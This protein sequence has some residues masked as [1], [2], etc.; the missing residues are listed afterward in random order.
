M[1]TYMEHRGS[2]AGKKVAWIGDGNNMCQ[3]YML[4]AKQFG[5][6]LHIACPES[7]EPNAALQKKYAKYI[8][9]TRSPEDAARNADLLVTDVWASMG[10]EEEQKKRELAFANYQVNPALLALA[11]S[12]AL[13]MHCLPA[14]EGEEIS[15]G[16]LNHAQSVVWDEAENRMHAQK[17][18]M[19]FLLLAQASA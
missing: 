17:A 10:Q 12:D 14:H 15:A 13:F 3:S 5:F 18:L 6:Q 16:L 2:I 1:Q 7:Y 8:H 9:I 11:N 19:E 4:A